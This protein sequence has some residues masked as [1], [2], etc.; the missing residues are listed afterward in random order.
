MVHDRAKTILI[1]VLFW[2]VPSCRTQESQYIAAHLASADAVVRIKVVE[3]YGGSAYHY[4]R[5]KVIKVFKNRTSQPIES[6]IGIGYLGVGDGIPI[7]RE[8]TVYLMGV[9]N[10][11]NIICWYLDESDT[12][13]TDQYSGLSHSLR[14]RIEKTKTGQSE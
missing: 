8:C 4:V 6:E 7:G 9:L 3:E 14:F 11:E 10:S 12:N 1:I 13:A 5:A 2:L